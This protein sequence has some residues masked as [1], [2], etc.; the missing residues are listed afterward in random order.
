MP[1]SVV[2]QTVNFTHEEENVPDEGMYY[3]VML[4]CPAD[5]QQTVNYEFNYELENPNGQQLGTETLPLPTLYMVLF[6]IWTL[7]L[8]IWCFN[9]LKFRH[10]KI[11]LHHLVT[12]IPLLKVISVF[13]DA[14]YWDTWSK[15]G[16]VTLWSTALYFTVSVVFELIFFTTLVLMAKGWCITRND[17]AV[18]ENKS[19]VVTVV[20]LV[21]ALLFYKILGGYYLFALIIMYIVILKYIFSS[22][23][24]NISALKSQLIL[25]ALS[26]PSINPNRTSV[27]FKFQTFRVFQALMV[28]YVFLNALIIVI[29]IFFLANVPW[30][31]ALLGETLEL[32]VFCGIGYLLRLRNFDLQCQTLD[33]GN[34]EE[35]STFLDESLQ[36]EK[37]KRQIFVV[38]NPPSIVDGKL[39]PSIAFATLTDRM[40]D[41]EQ[42]E[43]EELKQT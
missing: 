25:L 17:L 5:T 28:S 38:Q 14:I 31:E 7:L 3:F 33:V 18:V 32:G 27:Y 43:K 35:M 21:S 15:V 8:G 34:G 22:I 37:E 1:S 16:D 11:M 6:A 12:L 26:Y 23:T 42:Y 40:P 9:W 39:R 24:Y 13:Y 20:A 4:S 30:V 2:W 36:K 10:H 41:E 29:V 19:I